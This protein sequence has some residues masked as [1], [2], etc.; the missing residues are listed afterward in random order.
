MRCRAAV[1]ALVL[2]I[3]IGTGQYYCVLGGLLGI[4]LT[5]YGH[6]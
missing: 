5:Y 3:G 1:L 6:G 4:A 2:G